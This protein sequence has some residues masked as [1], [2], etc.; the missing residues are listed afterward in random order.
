MILGS[1]MV[2]LAWTGAGGVLEAS[3]L[4]ASEDGALEEGVLV[5]ER[6]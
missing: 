4:E 6:P 1:A 2:I 5:I 3:G